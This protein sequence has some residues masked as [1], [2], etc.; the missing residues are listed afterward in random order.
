MSLHPEPVPTVPEETARVAHAAFPKGNPYLRLRDSFPTLFDD[1]AFRSLFPAEG[2]PAASPAMLALVTLLQFAEGLADRQAAEAVRSRIDWKYLLGLPLTHA[3]FDHSVLAEFRARLLDHDAEQLLF[4]RL[5]THCGEQGML[6]GR[7][8]QRTDATHVLAA[9]RTLNRLELVG[10][11]MRRA[12]EALATTA[13]DWLA[14]QCP[15]A[16]VVRYGRRFEQYRLPRRET[17]RDALALTIGEDGFCLLSALWSEIAAGERRPG[18]WELPAVQTLRQV[19]IQ[20]Y[21]REGERVRLRTGEEL[22]PAPTSINSPQDDQ[23]RYSATRA[24]EW[25]GYKVHFTECCDPETPLLITDVQTTPAPTPDSEVLPEVYEALARRG[26]LPSTHLVD[27]G[28]TEAELLV[29]TA[30]RYGVRLVGP[31]QGDPSWQARNATGFAAREFA[32]DWEG[33]RVH[34]PAGQQSVGWKETTKHGHPVIQ[35]HFSALNCRRCGHQPQCTR[36]RQAGRKLTLLPQERYEA[37]QAVREQQTTVA[38]AQEYGARA[39]VEGTHS[40]AVRR[41]DLRHARYVGQRKVHLEHLLTATALNLLRITD[42]LAGTQRRTT[43]R[44]P[45]AALLPATPAC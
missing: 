36:A 1:E 20:Q 11:T 8:K 5:L 27:A 44:S 13:P 15:P 34:C 32:V 45:L 19:W 14:A 3:G 10:E 22:P 21:T 28:Y 16:W 39:G 2:Q 41:C 35:V 24:T 29:K 25:V 12:L 23:A 30:P 40:Q 7:G 38:F 37:V 42:W 31:V 26:V 6:K 17:E 43:R 4:E 33:K 18:L 9:L